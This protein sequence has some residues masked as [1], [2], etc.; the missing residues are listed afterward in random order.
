MFG[1]ETVITGIGAI[2]PLTLIV[3]FYGGYAPSSN[4]S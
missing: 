4:C 3:G 1:A 2:A